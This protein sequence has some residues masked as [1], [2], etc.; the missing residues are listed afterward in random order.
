[1]VRRDPNDES[2][3]GYRR[4]K[5]QLQHRTGRT[6]EFLH[7]L[8]VFALQRH[9]NSSDPILA[10]AQQRKICECRLE[11]GQVCC[12]KMRFRSLSLTCCSR[13]ARL[14]GGGD[15]ETFTLNGLPSGRGCSGP[16]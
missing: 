15:F 2:Q 12:P 14:T 7:L 6:P 9:N 5:P 8:R 1:M 10:L 3:K 4:G 11:K 13:C 16:A